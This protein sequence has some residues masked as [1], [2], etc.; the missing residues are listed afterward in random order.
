MVLAALYFYYTLNTLQFCIDLE[1]YLWLSHACTL[2]ICQWCTCSVCG[3]I[4]GREAWA[5]PTLTVQH[6]R[7]ILCICTMIKSH[8]K[9][10]IASTNPMYSRKFISPRVY[11]N[12]PQLHSKAQCLWWGK[13]SPMSQCLVCGIIVQ[14][15][16]TIVFYNG[17][18]VVPFAWYNT[19]TLIRKS[20]YII[21]MYGMSVTWYSMHYGSI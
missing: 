19:H 8:F 2:P 12:T 20:Y 17:V 11:D 5:S 13:H 15:S 3:F 4:I 6:C 16:Y 1:Y 9:G 7:N 21:C 14:V 10:K 18:W